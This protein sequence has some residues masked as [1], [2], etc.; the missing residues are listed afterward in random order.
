MQVADTIDEIA[1]PNNTNDKRR[2]G[3][4]KLT[5]QTLMQN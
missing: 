5:M 2:H 1:R 4:N 3:K